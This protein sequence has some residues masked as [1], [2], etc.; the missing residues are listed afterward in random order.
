MISNILIERVK[1]AE[2]AQRTFHERP[3]EWGR[4]DCAYLISTVLTALG[5]PNPLKDFRKYSTEAGAM[6]A[7]MKL[8]FAT[9]EEVLDE[10]LKLERITPAATLPGDIVG[11]P[12]EGDTGHALGVVLDADRVLAFCDLGN[13]VRGEVGSLTAAT[14][15]WRAV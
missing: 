1:A 3:F 2:L 9:V 6:R 14:I 4:N 12:G 10:S 15:A 8:G 7:L 11:I 13:G 5:H